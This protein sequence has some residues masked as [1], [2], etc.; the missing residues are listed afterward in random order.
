MAYTGR[1]EASGGEY[2]RYQRAQ[3]ILDRFDINR[4]GDKA[5]RIN[6]AEAFSKEFGISPEKLRSKEGI[7][8]DPRWPWENPSYEGMLKIIADK[9]FEAEDT[10]LA[11]KEVEQERF[12]AALS[13][14]DRAR[15]ELLKEQEAA[16]PIAER[17]QIGETSPYQESV[18][19]LRSGMEGQPIAGQEGIP[20]SYMEMLEQRAMAEAGQQESDADRIMREL[21]EGTYG[22]GGGLPK[23]AQQGLTGLSSKFSTGIQKLY[24]ESPEALRK[25]KAQGRLDTLMEE[26]KLIEKVDEETGEKVRMAADSWIKYEA[27]KTFNKART[28]AVENFNA[29]LSGG[30]KGSD[31]VYAQLAIVLGS[32][33]TG[34]AG[35]TNPALEAFN[36]LIDRD[37]ER[38]YKEQEQRLK[39]MDL[40]NEQT[41]AML[42]MAKVDRQ[43]LVVSELKTIAQLTTDMNQQA[44][45]L[46][47]AAKLEGDAYKGQY[48]T[49]NTAMQVKSLELQARMAGLLDKGQKTPES[50]RKAMS[51]YRSMKGSVGQ[52][53]QAFVVMRKESSWGDRWMGYLAK[54]T[55][56]IR[57]MVRMT[58]GMPP[59][60][61]VYLN[62]RTNTLAQ[63]VKALQ[64]SR[65]SD[66]D[67][68]KLEV[69]FPGVLDNEELAMADFAA[70]EAMVEA[71]GRAAMG[72]PKAFAQ[73][74]ALGDELESQ[75]GELGES[76]LKALTPEQKGAFFTVLK[77]KGGAKNFSNLVNKYISA[78]PHEITPGAAAATAGEY[79]GS[80]GTKVDNG[81]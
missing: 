72:D 42:S 32:I 68:K 75:F 6:V 66:F 25:G 71:A 36:R 63:V 79:L 34:L 38:Q 61:S 65:P 57:D 51:D 2:S 59:E 74:T 41:Q 49:Y 43:N 3:D 31:L 53:K 16:L 29:D 30:I 47:I 23:S 70:V 4:V 12:V 28:D 13:P 52:L 8:H 5:S 35:G 60:V 54:E 62:K 33:G 18:Q 26:G 40:T 67:W 76:G 45:I 48:R 64:G 15:L 11:K 27:Q 55:G 78:A 46:E 21:K 37:V 73:L 56:F 50:V 22:S 9:E 14:S 58:G 69:L 44:K 20:L 81:G 24:G 80:I 77:Q 10:A 1:E 39:N 19:D 17:T 7:Y